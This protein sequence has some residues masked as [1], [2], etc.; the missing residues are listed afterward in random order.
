MGSK[1]ERFIVSSARV[2]RLSRKPITVAVKSVSHI[3]IFSLGFLYQKFYFSIWKDTVYSFIRLHQP[4]SFMCSVRVRNKRF[5]CLCRELRLNVLVG[6]VLHFF[7]F[8]PRTLR[9]GELFCLYFVVWLG[10]RYLHYLRF[11]F[12]GDKCGFRFCFII[13]YDECLTR[14]KVWASKF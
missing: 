13:L 14:C 1:N 11:C 10:L 2:K 8:L 12:Y 6:L 7:L 5:K 9:F 4:G 3:C